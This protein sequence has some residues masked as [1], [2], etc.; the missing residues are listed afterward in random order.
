MESKTGAAFW[1]RPFEE[2]D[3]GKEW[4]Y[5]RLLASDSAAAYLISVPFQLRGPVGNDKVLSSGSCTDIRG[6]ENLRELLRFL[7]E[8][9]RNV[10]SNLAIFRLAEFGEQ[11]FF[12]PVASVFGSSD[13]PR[14]GH[15]TEF[16]PDFI[17][18]RLDFRVQLFEF[19]TP[20]TLDA[21]VS[22]VKCETASTC[23]PA[24]LMNLRSAEPERFHS[25][26]GG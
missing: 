4:T 5:L 12:A 3:V 10:L 21:P 7:V 13:L 6:L 25:A 9:F 15:G 16:A 14:L 22:S 23:S 1:P 17:D 18:V 20:R 26:T 8:G 24:S 11:R 2:N 19:F